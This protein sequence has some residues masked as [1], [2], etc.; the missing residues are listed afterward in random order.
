MGAGEM[1]QKLK[2][3]APLAEDLGL[4]PTLTCG[5]QLHCQG[6]PIL[7]SMGTRYIPMQTKH[8]Y[9]QYIFKIL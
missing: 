9:T 1:V 2:T 3:L 5:G 8:S 6:I 4:F 7:N